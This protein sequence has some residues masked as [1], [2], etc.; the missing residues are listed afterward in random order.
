MKLKYSLL[1]V[2]AATMFVT[3]N[4]FASA[5]GDVQFSCPGP[6]CEAQMLMCQAEREQEERNA[7]INA[8]REKA[9]AEQRNQQ[10]AGAVPSSYGKRR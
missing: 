5:C 3:T 2:A 10:S 1:A 9:L 6:M 7:R 8:E 4:S